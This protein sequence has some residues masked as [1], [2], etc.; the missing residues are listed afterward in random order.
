MN[1]FAFCW[2][3][4]FGLDGPDHGCFCFTFHRVSDCMANYWYTK[5]VLTVLFVIDGP[6]EPGDE[7][8]V[9]GFPLLAKE[10]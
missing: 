10:K 7:L 9:L 1:S 4:K 6:G 3:R 2:L 8:K 5:S